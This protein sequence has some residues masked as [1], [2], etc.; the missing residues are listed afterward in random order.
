[1]GES[2]LENLKAKWAK[3]KF[4][5]SKTVTIKKPQH[6]E[7][8]TTQFDKRWSSAFAKCLHHNKFEAEQ[9]Q[10]PLTYT[11]IYRYLSTSEN[12]KS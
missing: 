9:T 1:M 6:Y 11:S 2:E 8:T 4:K 7:R 3:W 12:D 10:R 5:N